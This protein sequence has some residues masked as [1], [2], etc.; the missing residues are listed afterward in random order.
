MAIRIAGAKH[1]AVWAESH[2]LPGRLPAAFLG[3]LDSSPSGLGSAF[4]SIGLEGRRELLWFGLGTAPEW[5]IPGGQLN[6][7][8]VIKRLYRVF[9]EDHPALLILEHFPVANRDGHYGLLC[10]EADRDW[11]ND[12]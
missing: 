9:T 5:A 1:V 6:D 3:A 8:Q 12:H 2:L 10:F 11:A 7:G 4:Q